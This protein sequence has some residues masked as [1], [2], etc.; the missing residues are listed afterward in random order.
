MQDDVLRLLVAG[1]TFKH[2]IDEDDREESESDSGEEDGGEDED[3]PESVDEEYIEFPRLYRHCCRDMMNRFTN[4]Q[5]AAVLFS[6]NVEGPVAE[7]HAHWGR[8]VLEI[9]S[10]EYRDTAMR[11]IVQGLHHSPVTL[12]EFAV[13]NL[14]NLIVPDT[15][16]PDSFN[17]AMSGLRALSLQIAT[18]S[19][20]HCPEDDM[21]KVELHTFFNQDLTRVWLRPLQTQLTSLTL[22]AV[23]YWGYFP[24]FPLKEL[25]LPQLVHLALGNYTF[26]HE[27]QL[28]WILS[29]GQTLQSLS[30]DDCP[31]LHHGTMGCG[32]LGDRRPRDV[33]AFQHIFDQKDTWTYSARWHDYFPRIQSGH[34]VLKDFRLGHGGWDENG[35]PMVNRHLLGQDLVAGRYV[36]FHGGT[37]RCESTSIGWRILTF[38][39]NGPYSMDRAEGGI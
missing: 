16:N 13:V 35:G 1:V 3:K 23:T 38:A 28:E 19:N 31:I 29:H 39:R 14:Q 24:D 10:L 12:K 25:Y 27:T 37:Y 32:F 6:P 26:S 21:T 20:E 18:E 30:L 7:E 5:S 11:M 2:D 22:Y 4:L 8:Q 33:N 15:V 34:P 17:I 36:T 9:D